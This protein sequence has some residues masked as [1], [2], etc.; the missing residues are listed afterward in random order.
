MR[1]GRR[2]VSGCDSRRWTACFCADDRRRHHLYPLQATGDDLSGHRPRNP[3]VRGHLCYRADR[4]AGSCIVRGSTTIR[5]CVCGRAGART[6]GVVNSQATES[7]DDSGCAASSPRVCCSRRRRRV[8]AGRDR[9]SGSVGWR[10]TR[11]EETRQ[12]AWTVLSER[13]S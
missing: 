2:Q 5:V 4:R 9:A 12:T 8:C 7:D 6:I 11:E 10:R 1:Q 13:G 3:C